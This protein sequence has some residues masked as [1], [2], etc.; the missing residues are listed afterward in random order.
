MARNLNDFKIDPWGSSALLEDDYDR[1]I[2]EFGIE[3]IDD[4]TRQK[5]LK[6]RFIRRKIIFGHR[7]LDDIFKA[8]SV[9]FAVE[10]ASITLKNVQVTY[11]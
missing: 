8:M 7:S 5:L 10:E 1:L 11:I 4:I 2:H 9:C 3:K 6:N